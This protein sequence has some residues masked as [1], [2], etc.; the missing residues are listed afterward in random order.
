M[1]K[2]KPQVVVKYKPYP[3]YPFPGLRALK[4]RL[5]P[6][7]IIEYSAWTKGPGGDNNPAWNA[8]FL[9]LFV[10]RHARKAR[11]PKTVAVDKLKPGQGLVIRTLPNPTKADR[12]SVQKS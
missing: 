8:V 10:L 4:G 3:V 7:R 9:G 5:S 6:R 11:G 2:P 1:A 12:R